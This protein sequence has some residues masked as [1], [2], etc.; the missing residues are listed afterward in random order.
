MTKGQMTRQKIVEE[1][2]RLFNQ[3]GF[4]GCSMSELMKA[5]GLE[6]GGIYRHFDSKEQLAA[7]AFEYAWRDAIQT[8][9]HDLGK[10]SNAVEWLKQFIDNFVHRRPT[11]P[12]GCP[13]LNTAIDADDGSP[14]LRRLALSALRGW[15]DELIEVARRGIQRKEI[16]RRVNPKQVADLVISSLEGALMMSRLERNTEVLST[17]QSF[18][19]SYLDTEVLL[20]R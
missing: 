18:L 8:R 13:L 3:N 14:V 19:N 11:V 2:A 17:A 1:A 12:G 15:R 5:T 6:K 10:V 9:T 16:R 7:E 20:Q 4:S